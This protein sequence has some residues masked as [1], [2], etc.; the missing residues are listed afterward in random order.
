MTRQPADTEAHKALDVFYITK[1]GGKLDEAEKRH[2]PDDL[3]RVA[4]PA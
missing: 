3:K 4:M 2:L 1:A